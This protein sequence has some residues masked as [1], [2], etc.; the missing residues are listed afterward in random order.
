[1]PKHLLKTRSRIPVRTQHPSFRPFFSL[2]FGPREYWPLIHFP[3]TSLSPHSCT[4]GPSSRVW[5]IVS[6]S[7]NTLGAFHS[8][9]LPY[10]PTLQPFHPRRMLD[11]ATLPLV[12]P[13]SVVARVLFHP[14]CLRGLRPFRTS[15]SENVFR[16]VD[17]RIG[18]FVTFPVIILLCNPPN[19]PLT[20]TILLIMNAF[21]SEPSLQSYC[22]PQAA[23]HQ[24]LLRFGVFFLSLSVLL[25]DPPRE[26]FDWTET[27]MRRAHVPQGRLRCRDD[28]SK[29]KITFPRSRSQN[30]KLIVIVGCRSH[31][32]PS[33]PSSLGQ[34][35]S[36][37]LPRIVL[38]DAVSEAM[39]VCPPLRLRVFVDDITAFIEGR[40]KEL[41]GRAE[42]VQK[43][44]RRDV[45]E[46]HLKLSITEGEKEGKKSD[47]VV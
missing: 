3:A 36:C 25:N 24:L 43:S 38:Q 17:H 16:S 40:N 23:H 34:T 41:A 37:L 47:R 9:S 15:P 19:N 4:V 14:Q 31:S 20:K 21:H 46:K 1:M 45:E 30:L 6:A 22:P 29:Q 35:Q 2:Y 42:K 44:I 5:M 28:Y 7:P 32:K 39:K 8:S 33:Q 26:I 11:C 27:A 13:S 12:F 10:Q 18:S